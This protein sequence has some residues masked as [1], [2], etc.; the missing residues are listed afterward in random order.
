[1]QCEA[2]TKNNKQC[3]NIALN[4]SNLCHIHSNE[5]GT[6]AI[7]LDDMVNIKITPCGHV[8]HHKCLNDWVKVKNN[9][10]I[11]RR[12]LNID[13]HPGMQKVLKPFV[14]NDDFE[15]IID[16]ALNCNLNVSDF[17]KQIKSMG[18]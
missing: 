15:L 11:C 10:P 12:E 16:I 7:C 2:F 8:F 3:K 18:Y 13:I 5:F 17:R 14:N 6:C 4:S 1:M 9:C